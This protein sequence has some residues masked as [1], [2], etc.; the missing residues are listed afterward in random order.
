MIQLK[1]SNT[2]DMCAE[3]NTFSPREV[4]DPRR[5]GALQPTR[6]S[7]ARS[8]IGT[9]IREGWTINRDELVLDRRG[10]GRIR[11]TVTTPA[12]MVTFLAFLREPSVG[13]RTF[14]IIG[15]SWDMVGTIIDGVASREQIDATERELPKL[16]EGRAPAGTLVWFRSN[17]SLRIFQHVRESLAA[18]R[19]PDAAKIRRIGYLMRNT[20]IDGN[21]TFGTMSFRAIP[22]GHP[23]Q[24]SYFAQMLAAYLMREVSVDAVEEI[25]R[26]DNPDGAITLS[27]E[28]KRF[29]GVG[30]AS[31][32]GLAMF[33]YNRPKLIN[34]YISA[35][36]DALRHVLTEPIGAKDSRLD[37]LEQ[38]LDR[39]IS[40]RALEATT[41]RIFT[42]S[43]EMA[44]DLRRIR[45]FVRAARRGEI[46]TLGGE[47]LLGAAHRIIRGKVSADA[48]ESFNALLLELIP[49]YCDQLVAERLRTDEELPLDPGT[50][51]GSVLQTVTETFAWALELPLNHSSHRDRVWYQSRAAEEPRSGPSE[52]IPGARDVVLNYPI[53]VRELR[54]ELLQRPDHEPIGVLLFERPELEQIARHVV[55]LRDHP[56]AVPHADP[57]DSDFVPVWLVRLMNSFIH[58]LDRTE[59]YL[60]RIIRGIIFEGA[61]FRNELAD[62]D[63]SAWWWANHPLPAV[64]AEPDYSVAVQARHTAEPSGNG[65]AP[66]P[67]LTPHE[68]SIIAPQHRAEGRI[69]LKLREA[70]LISGRAMQALNVPSGSWYGAREF[71]IAALL[72]SPHAISAF[73]ALLKV[74]LDGDGNASQWKHPKVNLDLAEPQ[75]D[76]QGQSML[77]VGHTLVNL[78]G[79]LSMSQR[80]KVVTISEVSPDHGVQGLQLALARYGVESEIVA[81]TENS[82]SIVVRRSENP[83]VT[84]DRYTKAFERFVT[85]GLE[86]PA[87]T[88]WNVYFPSNAALYPDTPISRQHTGATVVDVVV[89]GQK[90]TRQ[91]APEELL[92]VTDPDD[93]DNQVASYFS[94][95]S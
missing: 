5:L 59:D 74:K 67:V 44:A 54:D 93:A 82:L 17:R 8:F 62:A 47:T 39:T 43:H 80:R 38:L 12:G 6:L 66:T 37:L 76:C 2:L 35:Y 51:A 92:G 72:G 65:T 73:G 89:P 21:G 36:L 23:L 20:G 78:L 25:A 31:A 58:G 48:E 63:A 11:Y 86:V 52:E 49:E 29:I 1:G 19:Q 33:V 46:P 64:E 87:P 32:L 34:A 30:N 83:E 57:H 95:V 27:S 53:Q 28:V 94:S 88:W 90:V 68:S 69:V 81:A 71:F 16:Y 26:L 61:P 14:R 70:R 22:A 60:G 3:D 56:Y 7:A 85:T 18:G 40:Y 10:N 79:S 9:M 75:V 42:G 50:T 15:T 91:L 55:G 13:N 77:V 41:Y 45:T 24:N 84:M 4:M